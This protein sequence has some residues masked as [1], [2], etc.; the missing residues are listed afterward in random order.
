M[1]L[2]Q[3]QVESYGT[4]VG[5]FAVA[6]LQQWNAYQ[7]RQHAKEVAAKLELVNVS[8]DRKLADIHQLVNSGM[9]EQLKLN[10]V[11]ARRIANATGTID[12][13]VAATSAEERYHIHLQTNGNLVQT[14]EREKV[15][16]AAGVK[17]EQEAPGEVKVPAPALTAQVAA[18]KLNPNQ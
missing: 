3:S 11:M 17:A 18:D 10:A 4:L 16:F 12:D 7:T 5:I 15:A 9:T 2:T 1:I 6:V 14:A 8:K 13:V